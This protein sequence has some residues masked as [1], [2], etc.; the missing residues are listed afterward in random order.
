MSSKA[1]SPVAT[2]RNVI[3]GAGAV[4][5]NYGLASE[6]AIGATQGG[7]TFKV[8]REFRELEQDGTLG[9]IKGLISKTKLKVTL[10]VN[11][12]ELNT[13]NFPKYYAGMT[14]NTDAVEYDKITENVAV[15][16]GDYLDNVAIVA[17]TYDQQDVIIIIKNVLGNGAIEMALENQQEIVP[18]VIFTGTFSGSADDIPYEIRFPKSSADTTPPTISS[19][20]PT[21][22]ATGVSRTADITITFSESMKASTLNNNNIFIMKDSD[23]SV[24]EGTMTYNTAQT[25]V[26]FNPTN[27]LEA[28]TSY[29]LY[30]TDNVMDVA[31]NRLANHVGRFF[32]TGA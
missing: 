7:A 11:A 14:V 20:V 5:F 25:V 8:E 15:A 22:N 31:G 17:E 30:I 29:T 10:A 28:T 26:T 24:V 18:E 1:R 19:T 6:V 4:Y 9:P 21:A 27:S 2:P 23:S 3:M 12:L 16:T 13:T 32:Q